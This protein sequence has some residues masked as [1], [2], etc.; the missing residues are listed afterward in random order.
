MP[1]RTPNSHLRRVCRWYLASNHQSLWPPALVTPSS[2]HAAMWPAPLAVSE[3]YRTSTAM[4]SFK[5][6]L[7]PLV[8]SS[9]SAAAGSASSFIGL[10]LQRAPSLDQICVAPATPRDKVPHV[11][12]HWLLVR[13]KAARDASYDRRYRQLQ[14]D[15]QCVLFFSFAVSL[16]VLID[17]LRAAGKSRHIASAWCHMQRFGAPLWCAVPCFVCCWS[18]CAWTASSICRLRGP[19]LHL[20][21]AASC[22]AARSFHF[23]HCFELARRMPWG[24]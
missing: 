15:V 1:D 3:R 17:S 2:L 6:P 5:Q 16:W 24:E 19:W 11:K 7:L 10:Q 14:S 4:S 23:I 18:V 21:C 8:I 13:R 20:C 9:P 12:Q 22:C